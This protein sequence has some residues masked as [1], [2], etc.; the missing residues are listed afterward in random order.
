MRTG[1][2]RIRHTDECGWHLLAVHVHLHVP[3]RVFSD[4]RDEHQRNARV[5]RCELCAGGLLRLAQRRRRVGWQLFASDRDIGL[6]GLQQQAQVC[7]AAS[8][9][10][11][12]DR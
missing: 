9:E 2:D 11:A 1:V 10:Q 12:V 4:E 5:E 7:L 8:D 3:T 6:L